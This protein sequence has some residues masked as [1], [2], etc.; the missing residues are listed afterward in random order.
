M[1]PEFSASPQPPLSDQVVTW[2]VLLR[3]GR[4]TPKDYANFLA[5]RDGNPLHE[6]AWQ[7][8]T[9]TLNS[10][11][12]GRLGDNYPSGYEGDVVASP[13]IPSMPAAAAA[14]AS[15]SV[16]LGRRHFVGGALALG[17]CAVGAAYVGNAYYPLNGLT[18]DAAT[19]TGERRRYMLADGSQLLL[20]A[21]SRVD[22]EYT[23]TYRMLH[24]LEGAISVDVQADP[25]RPFL[26]RTAEGV[27]RSLGTR[28]MVRQ[29]ARRTLVVAHEHEV[30]V[31]TMAGSRMAVPSGTGTRF[32]NARIGVPRSDLV[33]DAAWEHGW[34][35]AH[36]RPLAE[37]VAALRPYRQG[38]LRVSMAAGGLP[39]RGTYPLDDSD[40]ALRALES[41]M[42]IQVSRLTPWFVSINVLS[43]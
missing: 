20:D 8:L 30:E 42:P 39:V 36:D 14:A 16:S 1:E 6:S 38:T 34:I 12:L 2:L 41:S 23:P 15:V 10:A 33:P 19:Q 7:Q 28:Y 31:E 37:I 3:S 21:R 25:T 9:G 18:S 43:T 11:T 32:D 13:D 4:A 22:L 24:L 35:E 17:V 29:Q 5:W 40:A 26:V 27:V